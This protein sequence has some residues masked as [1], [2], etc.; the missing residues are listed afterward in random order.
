MH[1]PWGGGGDTGGS[2]GPG[3]GGRGGPLQG[4][5]P[6]EGASASVSAPPPTGLFSECYSNSEDRAFALLVR[7]SRVWSRATCLHLA[8]EAD[9]KAFFAHEGVQVSEP[10]VSGVGAGA[11][12]M[13]GSADL[14]TSP[15]QWLPP[16]PAPCVP[17]VWGGGH[18]KGRSA[19]GGGPPG[20][21]H[22]PGPSA[23]RPLRVPAQVPLPPLAL[24]DP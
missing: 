2:R 1:W 3:R 22:C 9:T 5:A 23:P 20:L 10:L 6:G 24:T 14:T 11:E 4:L 8:A 15:G 7:R 21:P 13:G 18:R 19:P 12:Q 17:A 16:P